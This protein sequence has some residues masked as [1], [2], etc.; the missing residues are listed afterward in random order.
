MLRQ[1]LNFDEVFRESTSTLLEG[2]GESEDHRGRFS[3]FAKMPPPQFEAV[4]LREIVRGGGQAERRA[5]PCSRQAADRLRRRTADQPMR[6]S[7]DP[8]QMRRVL[9]NLVLNAMDA[10]PRA[11]ACRFVRRLRR[12]GRDWKSPTAGRD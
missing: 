5:V 6:I 12:P 1:V 9:S 11:D 10:M 4:D 3:D 7:A 8:D 2:I